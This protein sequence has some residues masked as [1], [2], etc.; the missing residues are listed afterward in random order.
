MYL[1]ENPQ[2]TLI[3]S[4]AT[5]RSNKPLWH[6]LYRI[7]AAYTWSKIYATSCPTLSKPSNTHA[8]LIMARAFWC[9]SLLDYTPPGWLLHGISVHAYRVS[10]VSSVTPIIYCGQLLGWHC[11]ITLYNWQLKYSSRWICES[12]C[13]LHFSCIYVLHSAVVLLCKY[14]YYI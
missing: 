9:D 2:L 13:N 7:L 3:N 1:F 14:L 5:S 11:I 12:W 4:I 10:S 6:H 8:Y